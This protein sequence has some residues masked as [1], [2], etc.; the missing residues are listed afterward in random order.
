LDDPVVITELER[1]QQAQMSGVDIGDIDDATDV[2]MLR[3]EN[4]EA[5]AA[6]RVRMTKL[7]VYA[8]VAVFFLWRLSSFGYVSGWNEKDL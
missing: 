5:A 2:P 1:L 7:V 3:D 8:L 4:A 6:R